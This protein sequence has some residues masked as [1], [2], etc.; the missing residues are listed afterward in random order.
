MLL[1]KRKIFRRI[2]ILT[3]KAVISTPVTFILT[4][5]E[6][7]LKKQLQKFLKILIQKTF[8]AALVDLIQNS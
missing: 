2:Y 4:V 7:R 6:G 5:M 3:F 1:V 8:T